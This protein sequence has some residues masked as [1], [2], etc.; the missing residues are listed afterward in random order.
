MNGVQRR[1][2]D[3]STSRRRSFSTTSAARQTRLSPNPFAI[4]PS[5]FVLHG[6]ITMPWVR[7]EPL[8]T[9]A[10]WS[11]SPY[12]TSASAFTCANE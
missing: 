2:A 10:A 5:V 4:A 9:G 7:N 6:A 3:G 1:L 12:V 8:D 11:P